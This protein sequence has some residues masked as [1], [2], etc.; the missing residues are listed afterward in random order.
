MKK[1][2]HTVTLSSVVLGAS[3][4]LSN[5]SL[6]QPSVNTMNGI[7]KVYPGTQCQYGLWRSG[8][9]K[10][11]QKPERPAGVGDHQS[12]GVVAQ[13]T[14]HYG[15][16]TAYNGTGE[17]AQAFCP[18]VRQARDISRAWVNVYDGNPERDS[19]VTCNVMCA[20]GHESLFFSSRNTRKIGED[21]QDHWTGWAQLEFDE[22]AC[23]SRFAAYSLEC[24][25]PPVDGG[26]RTPWGHVGESALASY[27]VTEW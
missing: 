15:N 10:G 4:A 6:A 3:L 21:G 9:K 17:F 19:F 12:P 25:L 22:V 2:L 13:D 8:V 7:E 1:M 24:W 23:G 20:N 26:G 11:E 16:G 14:I 5:V 27:S 18:A